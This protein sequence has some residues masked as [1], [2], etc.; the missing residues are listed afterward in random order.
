M[1]IYAYLCFRVIF[2]QNFDKAIMSNKK[3]FTLFV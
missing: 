3:M 1:F 2:V